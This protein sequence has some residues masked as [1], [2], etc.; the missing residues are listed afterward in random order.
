M[1]KRGRCHCGAILRFRRTEHGYKTRC[2]ACGAVVR[3]RGKAVKAGT[4]HAPPP[5]A[6]DFDFTAAPAPPPTTVAVVEM[7]V[8]RQQ[9]APRAVGVWFWV[10][11]GT[12]LLVV[13]GL[14]AL[15]FWL[16]GDS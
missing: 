7:E 14:S 5:P 10:C 6:N 2:A 4:R 11:W 8:W 9:E 15:V 16:V 3:L 13:T 1:A 12:G